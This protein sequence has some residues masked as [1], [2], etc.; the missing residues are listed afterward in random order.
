MSDQSQLCIDSRP[1][2]DHPHCSII[3]EPDD[4]RI[5]NEFGRPMIL[6]RAVVVAATKTSG[7]RVEFLAAGSSLL[8]A[9][10]RT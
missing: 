9:E 6:G 3:K 2:P 10:R 7:C 4:C 5:G 1:R 8:N